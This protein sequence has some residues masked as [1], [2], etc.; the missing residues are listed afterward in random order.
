MPRRATRTG[1][2]LNRVLH[3][4]AL[5]SK[6]VRLPASMGVW[7]P[8]ADNE[9]PPRQVMESIIATFPNLTAE[10]LP[11]VALLSDGDVSEFEDDLRDRG[12]LRPDRETA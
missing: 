12:L 9:R 8:V 10:Q 6:D 5:I 11:F 4:V 2:Y 1:Y 3:Q 7:L